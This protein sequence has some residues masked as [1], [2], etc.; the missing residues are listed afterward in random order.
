MTQ[1]AIFCKP[2]DMNTAI[3]GQAC[4]LKCAAKHENARQDTAM[5]LLSQH[6]FHVVGKKLQALQHARPRA[7]YIH[8][9]ERAFMLAVHACTVKPQFF[10]REQLAGYGFRRF[11][12][13]RAIEPHEIRALEP[14]CLNLRNI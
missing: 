5:Q 9:Y 10:L 1:N 3:S 7:G 11:A 4:L 6:I 12:Q 13:D 8:P 14:D 2:S